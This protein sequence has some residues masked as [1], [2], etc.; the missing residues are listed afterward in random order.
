MGKRPESRRAA[1]RRVS[2]G[3]ARAQR[4]QSLAIGGVLALALV[5]TGLSLLLV[6][7]EKLTAQPVALIPLHTPAAITT[8]STATLSPPPATMTP[9]P[10]MPTPL[11]ASTVAPLP[12]ETPTLK[13]TRV[14]IEVEDTGGRLQFALPVS[15]NVSV[16]F[17]PV[18]P[19]FDFDAPSGTTVVASERGLVVFAGWNP[20]GY[21]NLVVISHT[22]GWQT[23]YAHLESI[24]V[25]VG[26]DVCRAC[27]LGTVGDTGFSSGPHLHFEIRQGC[28]FYNPFT[29]ERIA[30][31]VPANY[32]HDPFGTPICL[33]ADT[34][35]PPDLPP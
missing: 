23:W 9:L 25:N 15:G 26:E 8:Y 19:A 2:R 34:T 13:G 3:Q 17:S 16:G 21:G 12:T 33:A 18:H 29:G 28:A 35:P 31:R 11:P 27:P 5:A 1:R 6:I 24:A 22:S 30:G 10:S 4:I 14:E 32:R 20:R 7:S